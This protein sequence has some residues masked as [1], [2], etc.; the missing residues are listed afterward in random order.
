[1]KKIVSVI[2]G[3]VLYS[4]VSA[5]DICGCGV[6]S[7]YVGILPE[8][9]KKIIGVRYRYSS[10]QSHIG[11][12]G[13]RTYL[14]TDEHFHTTELWGGWTI[15]K[16]IRLMGYVP[17]GFNQKINQE[18]VTRKN[19]LGD[20]GV[21]GFYRIFDQR[22]TTDNNKMLIHTLWL[23]AGIKAPT[24]KYEQP[25]KVSN[26]QSLNVFQLGTGS[27]DFT[28][29]GM[30][31]FRLQDM[32]FNTMVSY[33]INTPNRNAYRYG[34][35]F[36]SSVQGYYKIRI[37][38]KLT[39]APNAGLMYEVA[40]KDADAG[41]RVGVTGGNVLLGSMGAEVNFSRMA[42]GANFQIPIH[43]QLA[44]GFAKAGNRA[45]VHVAFMF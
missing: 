7:Y 29:N 23:G 10:L 35:K 22:T 12:G 16:K 31:D 27:T 32:G 45:M 17:M 9:S 2:I 43:Q 5:C 11:A 30:Y 3:L 34:N 25:V 14:T 1:M 40:D 26:E 44:G 4:S 33:K 28:I 37:Q 42:I 39:L 13:V 24:G 36:L 21:Q 8:F 6:G 15:G 20:I 18:G 38:D 19:G 41:Y